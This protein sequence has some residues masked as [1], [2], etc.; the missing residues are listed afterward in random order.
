MKKSVQTILA[1]GMI[2]FYTFSFGQSK[3]TAPEV[4]K[5]YLDFFISA[6]GTDLNYGES[7]KAMKDFKKSAQGIQIGLSLQTTIAPHFSLVPE[8]SFIMRGGKLKANNPLTQDESTL[9][10]YT[11][12]IPVLARLHLGKFHLNAGP[13]LGYNFYGTQKLDGSTTDLSFDN[14]SGGFKRFDAGLQMGGGLTFKIKQKRA[15]L[16]IRYCYGLTNVSYEKEVYNRSLLIRLH[17][18]KK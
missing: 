8:L 14:E 2:F 5:T 3:S 9:R 17:V 1:I 16:D 10:F 12:E 13:S 6:V 4:Q 11:M 15:V 18:S 7:N